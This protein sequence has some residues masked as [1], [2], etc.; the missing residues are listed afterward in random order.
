VIGRLL[1]SMVKREK[2]LHLDHK[3]FSHEHDYAR[4]KIA[5]VFFNSG[6]F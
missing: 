5:F 3:Q 6:L 2:Q 1:L 4:E